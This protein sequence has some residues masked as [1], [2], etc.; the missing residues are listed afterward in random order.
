[1]RSPVGLR[2][3]PPGSKVMAK[4]VATRVLE[5][6]ESAASRVVVNEMGAAPA[7]AMVAEAVTVGRLAGRV[8]LAHHTEPGCMRRQGRA[9][10]SVARHSTGRS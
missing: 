7:S 5:M 10:L 9:P 8:V 3:R 4:V 2:R 6:A 1:M